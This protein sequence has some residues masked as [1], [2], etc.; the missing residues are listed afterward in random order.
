[1]TEFR[2]PQA[3]PRNI[4]PPE[5]I[6]FTACYAEEHGKEEN[7]YLSTRCHIQNYLNILK[8]RSE[9]TK[10]SHY[11]RFYV[12]SSMAYFGVRSVASVLWC[13]VSSVGTLV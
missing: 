4:R 9:N 3:T 6:F 7:I 1:M 5:N 10:C 8:I 12:L 11:L 13:K 2:L